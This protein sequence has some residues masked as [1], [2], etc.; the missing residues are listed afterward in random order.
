MNITVVGTGYVGLANALLLAQRNKGVACDIDAHRIAALRARQAPFADEDIHQ[1]LRNTQLN[2]TAT[3]NG[4]AAYNNADYVVVA[5][6]TNYDVR[7]D[8]FDT[9]TVESVVTNSL[10]ANPS[11]TIVIKSTVPVGFTANLRQRMGA[12]NIIFSP[13]FLR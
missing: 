10:N 2:L 7:H 8:C 11:A 9:A 4:A 13:E 6:P 12:N 5:T 1:F 3:T